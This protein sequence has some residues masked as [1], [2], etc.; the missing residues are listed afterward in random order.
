MRSEERSR[1]SESV[2]EAQTRQ[3]VSKYVVP[4]VNEGALTVNAFVQENVSNF[5]FA[6]F[7]NSLSAQG[8]GS[9]GGS[10]KK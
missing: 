7:F 3:L 1:Q 2:L 9:G 10:G 5:S 6:N 8:D 4:T